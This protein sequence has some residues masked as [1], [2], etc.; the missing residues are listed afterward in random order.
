MHAGS[1]SSGADYYHRL[2]AYYHDVLGIKPPT[3]Q[4]ARLL[5]DNSVGS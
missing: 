4:E 2:S 5:A 3:E 1:P